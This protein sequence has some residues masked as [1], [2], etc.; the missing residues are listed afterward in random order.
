ME[1]IYHEF[2]INASPDRV[3]EAISTPDGLSAWWTL[4]AE[5][6]PIAG[7]IYGLNFGPGYAWRAAVA[8]CQAPN[9][10][11]WRFTVADP[12]W[13]GTRLRFLLREVNRH[14]VVS[15]AHTGWPSVSEHFRV[16]SFCWA[17]Y[18][19]LLKRYV[20]Q[21]EVIPYDRRLDA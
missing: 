11:E 21:G 6:V 14:T 15:F 13:V 7:H 9:H 12:D 8:C 19:R 18:L 4:Q 2:P 3:F 1:D 20:E 17:M 10:I 16:S 5:G